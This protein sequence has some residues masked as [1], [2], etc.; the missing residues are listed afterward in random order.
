MASKASPLA[1][2]LSADFRLA[3]SRWDWPLIVTCLIN[4][5]NHYTSEFLGNEEICVTLALVSNEPIVIHTLNR[6]YDRLMNL[7]G[8]K[9]G[10]WWKR[11]KRKN[12]GKIN[13]R[14]IRDRVPWRGRAE[15]MG[16]EFSRFQTPRIRNIFSYEVQ[17]GSKIC[18]SVL[19]WNRQWGLSDPKRVPRCSTVEFPESR[20]R[21]GDI[22]E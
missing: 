10:F 9:Q 6:S 17:S 1:S 5:D 18:D 3:L 14:V 21:F 8:D 19:D 15:K 7:D 16:K 2:G 22:W 13:I 4:S 11:F 20:L 12:A